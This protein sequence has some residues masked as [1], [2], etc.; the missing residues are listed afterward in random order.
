LKIIVIDDEP[1][2]ADTLVEILQGEGC[3]AIAVSDSAS[4]L[5]WAPIMRPDAVI[6]DVIMPGM[7][8]IQ[9]AIAILQSVPDCRVILF[10]GQ[11]ASLELVQQAREQGYEFEI[12]A[13]PI[14]PAVL[15]SMLGLSHA[16]AEEG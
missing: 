10:S 5:K 6:C 7:N 16:P 4:A 8:G 9:T 11:A 14:N 1:V 15:L 12:L 13:K 3:E 2:I